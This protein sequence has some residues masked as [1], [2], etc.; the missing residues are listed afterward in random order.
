MAFYPILICVVA[1]VL[2][3]EGR[4][5]ENEIKRNVVNNGLSV[6]NVAN[7]AVAG[8]IE[9]AISRNGR[10]AI[11]FKLPLKHKM[12]AKKVRTRQFDLENAQRRYSTLNSNQPIRRPVQQFYYTNKRQI[13]YVPNRT[14]IQPQTARIPTKSTRR[15][16]EKRKMKPPRIMF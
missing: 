1:S 2:Y 13:P 7:P 14:R 11:H 9:N 15:P 4:Y 12:K 16:T 5:T 6:K 10:Q 8:L 3:C